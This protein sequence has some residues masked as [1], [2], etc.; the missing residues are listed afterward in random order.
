MTVGHCKV[1]EAHAPTHI[2]RIAWRG[3]LCNLPQRCVVEHARGQKTAAQPMVVA[4]QPRYEPVWD[5]HHNPQ[6]NARTTNTMLPTTSFQQP[7]KS[8]IPE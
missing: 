5:H 1:E 4:M 7:L 8:A 2:S 3:F 6:A